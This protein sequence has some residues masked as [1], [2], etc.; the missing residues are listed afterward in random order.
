MRRV[1]LTTSDENFDA[2]SAAESVIRRVY[3]AL[4]QCEAGSFGLKPAN[5]LEDTVRNSQ[6]AALTESAAIDVGGLEC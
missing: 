6:C 5:M 3:C 1:K 2:R 4:F